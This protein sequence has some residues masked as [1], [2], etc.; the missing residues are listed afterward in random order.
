M[1]AGLIAVGLDERTAGVALIAFGT[2]CMAGA[3]VVLVA[4]GGVR[5][6]RPGAI[7]AV[8]PLLALGGLALTA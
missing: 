5:Y 2:A 4:T 8:P 6:L 7:Q 1:V 3:G